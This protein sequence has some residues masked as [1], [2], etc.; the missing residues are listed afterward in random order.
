MQP[1]TH[2]ISHIH[3]LCVVWIVC[4]SLL[5]H[6]KLWLELHLSLSHPNY[7]R[8]P[9]DHS[10]TSKSIACRV[11][12]PHLDSTAPLRV[13]EHRWYVSYSLDGVPGGR[14]DPEMTSAQWVDQIYPTLSPEDLELLGECTLEPGKMG[15]LSAMPARRFAPPLS[16][17]LHH[18]DTAASQ[19]VTSPSPP[20]FA[21]KP[22]R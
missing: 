21:S 7:P 18:L 5:P 6:G 17:S 13:F 22:T 9:S 20:V 16:W 8:S 15:L 1:H 4:D 2:I 14:I 19:K 3:T 10:F 11:H 12:A